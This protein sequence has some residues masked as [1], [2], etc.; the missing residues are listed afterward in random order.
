MQVKELEEK[1]LDQTQE[2]E[3]LRSELVSRFCR[4]FQRTL[5]Q[6]DLIRIL[7]LSYINEA[8]HVNVS[9]ELCLMVGGG[10]ADTQKHHRNLRF[11]E[12]VSS[13]CCRDPQG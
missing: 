6:F 10:V 2:V 9:A 13:S 3:R 12:D 4:S 5:L 8:E 1:L 7:R 11:Q